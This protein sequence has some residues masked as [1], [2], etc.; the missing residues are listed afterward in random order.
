[1]KADATKFNLSAGTVQPVVSRST[2]F[3]MLHFGRAEYDREQPV[4]SDSIR[5]QAQPIVDGLNDGTITIDEATKRLQAI[6]L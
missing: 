5:K 3:F 6:Y 4:L 2:P 1:M